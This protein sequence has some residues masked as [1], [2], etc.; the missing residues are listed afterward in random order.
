VQLAQRVGYLG[1]VNYLV[2]R[3][4]IIL[5]GSGVVIDV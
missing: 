4:S 3:A 5:A 1:G 2:R